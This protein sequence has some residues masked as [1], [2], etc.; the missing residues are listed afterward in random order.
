MPEQERSP[1]LVV[2]EPD[3]PST[4][5][6]GAAHPTR[7]LIASGPTTGV[8]SVAAVD[9]PRPQTGPSIALLC[10]IHS[11]RTRASSLGEVRGFALSVMVTATGTQSN[12]G[13]GVRMPRRTTLIAL[14][15][16]LVGAALA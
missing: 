12:E 1:G 7:T 10:W 13:R 9:R 11:V 14:V 4:R 8:P 15:V 16:A 5:L 2:I 3:L 6:P